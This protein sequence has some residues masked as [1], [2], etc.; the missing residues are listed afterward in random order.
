[1]VL[2]N[3]TLTCQ[4]LHEPRMKHLGNC[5]LIL[6]WQDTW[7]AFS[8]KSLSRIWAVNITKIKGKISKS[9]LRSPMLPFQFSCLYFENHRSSF[10]LILE[11]QHIF[12]RQ[13]F[14]RPYS[15]QTILCSTFG[16]T[17]IFFIYSTRKICTIHFIAWSVIHNQGPSFLYLDFN[18]ILQMQGKISFFQPVIAKS[19]VRQS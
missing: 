3:V 7:L 8:L 2:C 10:C 15:F 17:P 19:L 9:M 14:T 11:C 12:H 6:W 16:Q 1:M 5:H 13:N 4:S 18:R